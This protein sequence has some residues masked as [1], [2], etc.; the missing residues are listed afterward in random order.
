MTRIV[1]IGAGSYQFGSTMLGDLFHYREALRGAEVVLVDVDAEALATMA[2]VAQRLNRQ[3]GEPFTFCATDDR[4][5]A[6]RGAQF[7]VISVAVRRNERWQL[8]FEI[9]NRHGARQVL[10]ENG[11]PGGLFH[12]LRNIPL[13]LDICRDI[14]RICPRA[15][16]LNLTNPEGR[17]C[18]AV[19]RYTGLQFVGLCHG[20]N[21]AREAIGYVLDLPPSE[22]VPKA[23][24][25]NHLSWILDLRRKGTG[26]DLYPAFKRRIA[27]RDVTEIHRANKPSFEV[28]LSRFLLDTYGFWPLPSD[29]HVGEYLAYA[30]EFCG[31]EGYDF[32]YW[33][34]V[35][36][37]KR[38]RLVRWA[39]GEEP[40]E[41]LLRAPSGE[42]V[43]PIISAVL[44]NAHQYEL[45][46]NVP[47]AGLIPNLPE[48]AIVEVPGIVDAIGVHG[49]P[50][51]PLPEPIAAMCRT[52]VAVIDRVVEAG[53]HGDRQAAFQAL[54]LDPVIASAAQAQAIL[55]EMLEVHRP[56]LPQFHAS[57]AGGGLP[58][59]P[60]A[61]VRQA[62]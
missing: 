59:S 50:I 19:A 26:E 36:E 3:T 47:N 40:A 5:T 1:L 51:G 56:F 35:A 48:W 31:L 23:G 20:I 61:A 21:M 29:D 13:L 9:P 15:L 58:A 49:L 37:E 10:G 62:G 46:V 27:E 43:V 45:S 33:S 7:V 18:L 22:I 24:G 54:L 11:G 52:Q 32:A 42:R 16:V 25:I 17:L 12:A 41:A 6:L 28:R 60:A 34:R 53:V 8:D 55:D 30:W 44:S 38:Q 57:P 14:E 4:Q 2:A 39:S